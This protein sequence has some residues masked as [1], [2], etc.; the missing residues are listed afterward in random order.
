MKIRTIT[1][2][3]TFYKFNET[4][5]KEIERAGAFLKRAKQKFIDNGIEVQDIRLATNSWT[6]YMVGH[7]L[8]VLPRM[9]RLLETMALKAGFSCVSAGP[10]NTYHDILSIPEYIRATEITF[11]STHLGS[12]ATGIDI[13]SCR[14]TASAIQWISQQT[15]NGFGNFRFCALASPKAGIPFFPAGFSDSRTSFA[16]GLESSDLLTKTAKDEIEKYESNLEKILEVELKKIENICSEIE[17]E[18]GIPFEGIDA[19][20]VPSLAPDESVM[21]IFS[22][23]GIDTIGSPASI[24]LVSAIT[25]TIKNLKIKKCGFSG[26]MLPVM[27]DAGLAKLAEAG[28]L[29]LSDLLIC[30]ALCGTGLDTIPLPGDISDASLYRILLD[31][32]TISV[33]L[34]KPLTARLLPVPGKKKGEMTEFTS[35]FVINTAIINNA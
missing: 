1:Y 9:F 22:H 19:S 10:A 12:R 20:I 4:V 21:K 6:E 34:D 18:N 8:E 14:A 23:F 31:V 5:E 2:F 33:R 7:E 25:K 35:E 32:A 11:F 26:L 17:K 28:K 16:V 24:Y 3:A 27:E 30:S 15:A 29:R 13:D